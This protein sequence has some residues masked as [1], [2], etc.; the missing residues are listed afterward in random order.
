MA[1]YFIIE[2]EGNTEIGENFK[3]MCGEPKSSHLVR[4]K[5]SKP[6]FNLFL[7]KGLATLQNLRF[8]GKSFIAE[9]LVTTTL[10]FT[11]PIIYSTYLDQIDDLINKEP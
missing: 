8:G 7:N 10:D 3:K 11:L 9:R 1:N 4:C 2:R 6:K 5:L